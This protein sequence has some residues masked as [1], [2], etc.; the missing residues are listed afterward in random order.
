MASAVESV[1][2]E[3]DFSEFEAGDDTLVGNDGWRSSQ[4]DLGLHGTVDDVFEDGNRS[5][6]IGYNIPE[7][8]TE[9][10]IL[11][12]PVNI[13]PLANDSLIRFSADMA[14]IDSDVGGFDSF[15][16][17]IFNQENDLLGSVVF[18]NSEDAFGIWRYDSDTFHDLSLGF[19]HATRYRLS[20]TIDYTENVWSAGL[21]DI[22]LFR[23]AP[24]TV[25]PET[26]NLGDVAVEWEI[27]EPDNPG[28]NWLYFD[29]WSLVEE[30]RETARPGGREPGLVPR[31][32]R[33]RNG[34]I[35]LSWA[36][37]SGSVFVVE[38]TEDLVNWTSVD[39]PEGVVAGAE[40]RAVFVDRSARGEA[41]RFY[42]VRKS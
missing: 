40:E 19:D 32:G 29:N 11:W 41:Q 39:P 23:E 6:T 22:S 33:T 34:G 36:A 13:D 28:S 42:R 25:S 26:R 3:T 1:L 18:D 30:R 35:R 7:S 27:S 14:V 20:L 37:A 8:G 31:I 15:Y 5:G 2:Y 9:V 16:F 38:S 4:S 10:V 17:S 12:R 24:F 21:D